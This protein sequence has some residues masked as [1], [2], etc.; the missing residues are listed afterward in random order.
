MPCCSTY[1][2]IINHANQ[3]WRWSLS[4][5]SQ[6]SHEL[7][8]Q[9]INV[10]CIKFL[11]IWTCAFSSATLQKPIVLYAYGM[12]FECNRVMLKLIWTDW[13]CISIWWKLLLPA[14]HQWL[15]RRFQIFNF[16]QDIELLLSQFIGMVHNWIGSASFM[17][18]KIKV[19]QYFSH[20]LS[21]YFYICLDLYIHDGAYLL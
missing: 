5:C 4:S 7:T 11:T 16:N 3:C 18:C 15:K 2:Y 6:P 9:K 14:S 19:I 10:T 20:S 12:H 8:D 13:R 21:S 1:R 17:I